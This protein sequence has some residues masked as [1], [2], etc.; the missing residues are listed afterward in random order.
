MRRGRRLDPK[1]SPWRR[2]SDA[3][4]L[5]RMNTL[6]VSWVALVVASGL[7]YGCDGGA[8]CSFNSDCPS[9]SFCDRES[10]ACVSAECSDSQPCPDGQVC[11]SFGECLAAPDAGVEDGGSSDGG[12]SDAGSADAGPADAGPREEVC[13]P[14]TAGSSPADED[15]DGAI[16]EGCPWHFGVPHA[17]IQAHSADD[18]VAVA[19]ISEDALRLWMTA[20]RGDGTRGVFVAERAA[21]D[22]PFSAA[23]DITAALGG[24]NAT[25]LVMTADE[26]EIVFDDDWQTA[27]GSDMYRATRV[28]VSDPF[29][30]PEP[31][32]ELNTP[33]AVR[34]YGP[35]LSPD[36]LEIFFTRYDA[37]ARSMWHARRASRTQSFDA[38]TRIVVPGTTDQEAG[39][40]PSADGRT[41]FFVRDD[42]DGYRILRATRSDPTTLELDE[43]VAVPELEGAYSII[44]AMSERTREVFVFSSR[45]WSPGRTYGVWRAEICRDGPCPERTIDCPPPGARSPD[46]L[47]CYTVPG[48]SEPFIE[49]SARCAAAGGGH[50]VTLHS[51]AETSFVLGLVG[52]GV[53][54]TAAN[55]RA[56]EGTWRW[57]WPER[58]TF[59][60]PFVNVQ[61]AHQGGFAME[62]IGGDAHDCATYD[63]DFTIQAGLN[64]RACESPAPVVCE[65]ELWPAW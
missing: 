37:G 45:A 39:A 24:I 33:G 23:R 19:G 34:D 47:H 5:S 31:I 29:G 41:L 53:F 30:P 36:G 20:P 8:A 64:D 48:V 15:G 58:T 4:T 43:P 17:V 52:G 9:G 7:S 16:D 40:T 51:A 46:G 3:G 21:V 35:R 57:D 11:T 18:L 56:T 38:P 60:E 59:E 42:G 32:T 2:A 61:W 62:P 26:L 14:S 13:T 27:T 28:S 6:R 49:A 1:H 50:L 22:A 63:P 12:S 54:W 44:A 55:D 65:R 25:T 10:G